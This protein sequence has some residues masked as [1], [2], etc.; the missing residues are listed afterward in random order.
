LQ[1]KFSKI[2]KQTKDIVSN[3]NEF[4]EH[5]LPLARIKKIMKL[6]DEVKVKIIKM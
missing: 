5:A 6:D 4:K 2:E 1:D 3:P